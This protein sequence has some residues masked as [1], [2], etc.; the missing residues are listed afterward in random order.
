MDLK[1]NKIPVT[2]LL[3]NKRAK[4]ILC[5]NLPMLSNPYLLLKAER[6][7]L[8]SVLKL[9]SGPDAQEITA[10]MVSDLEAL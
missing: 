2:E 9:A 10:R 6:M 1:N 4:L 3:K 5:R 8:E 7:S